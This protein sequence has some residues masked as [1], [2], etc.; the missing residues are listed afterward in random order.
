MSPAW[1]VFSYCTTIN[2]SQEEKKNAR[3]KNR[4]YV[5]DILTRSSFF[6]SYNG[7]LRVWAWFR[8]GRLHSS[9]TTNACVL[10]FVPQPWRIQEN[11]LKITK[12]LSWFIFEANWELHRRGKWLTW[13]AVAD[14]AI[15]KILAHGTVV[16]GRG[17][18]FVHVHF[19]E[20]SH[21]AGRT[22]GENNRILRSLV[23]A[24]RPAAC[25]LPVRNAQSVGNFLFFVIQKEHQPF[26]FFHTQLL[27]VLSGC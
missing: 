16:A 6:Q 24:F 9:L 27:L 12:L 26:L 8:S 1:I 10:A 25:F 22:A 23:A 4:H 11:N 7:V 17:T 13:P 14:V 20:I 3:L 15:N 21:E 18:T 19:T 2:S 5:G